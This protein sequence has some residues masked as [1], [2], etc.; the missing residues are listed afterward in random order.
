MKKTVFVIGLVLLVTGALLGVTLQGRSKTADASAR[1]AP[2]DKAARKVLAYACPMHPAYRSDKPGK[3]PCC[4]MDLE[5]VVTDPATAGAP[6]ASSTTSADTEARRTIGVAVAPVER[7]AGARS[8]RL[9]GRVVPDEGRVYKLNAGI[10]GFIQNV[11]AVTT[12]SRVR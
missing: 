12:G 7:A 6:A 9:F 11:S 1:N 8:L 3:A 5:L 4:G 10:D 2:A